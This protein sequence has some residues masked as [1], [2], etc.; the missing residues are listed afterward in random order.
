MLVNEVINFENAVIDNIKV[1]NKK[2]YG[3]QRNNW[4]NNLGFY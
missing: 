4:K 2:W 3:L 1:I